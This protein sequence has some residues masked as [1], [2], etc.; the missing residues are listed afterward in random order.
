MRSPAHRALLALALSSGLAALAPR[1]ALAANAP[2][3]P[4]SA[5]SAVNAVRPEF[6]KPFTAAQEAMKAN[7]APDALA[8]LKEAEAVGNLSPYEAY[9][10]PRLRGPALYASGDMAGAEKDLQTVL[11][12]SFLPAEDRVGIIKV[13][14]T[15]YYQD[16]KY[17]LAA[18]EMQKFFDAGGNDAQIHE[19][20]PNSLYLAKKYPEAAKAYATFVDS[21]I[22]AGRKPDAKTLRVLASAQSLGADDAGYEKTIEKLAVMYPSPEY[23]KQVLASA[24]RVDKF[25]DRLYADYYRLRAAALGQV[26]DVERLSYASQAAHAG[27]PAEALAVLDAGL[28]HNAFTGTDTAEAKKLR[29]TVSRGAAQDRAQLAANE[30]AARASKDGEALVN[31]GLAVA[32]DGQ[33]EKGL[34][35][36]QQGFAKDGLKHP[37]EAKLH[38]GIVQW[39][40]GHP[41]DALKTFQ[42]VGGANGT[43]SIAHAW[44]LVVQSGAKPA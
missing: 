18:D 1:A 9:L 7:N 26:P 22:A 40:A 29:D 19:L 5:A 44:T 36:M 42:S 2:P 17:D 32:M 43:A 33:A 34:A 23:W 4:A 30:N 31:L 39:R 38:L 35:L 37:E 12:S 24:R 41:D 3:A 25:D 8:R 10:I 21:E 16:K 14:A 15:A 27:Y 28:A 13:L 6:G 20:L 11:D